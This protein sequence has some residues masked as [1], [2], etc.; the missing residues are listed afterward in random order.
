LQLDE[1]A[2]LARVIRRPG[3]SFKSLLRTQDFSRSVLV[4]TCGPRV[5]SAGDSLA[6]VQTAEPVVAI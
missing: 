5:A 6:V 4:E 3:D 1:K 2:L